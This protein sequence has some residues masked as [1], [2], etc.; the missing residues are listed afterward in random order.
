MGGAIG[1]ESEPGRG[2]TFSFTARFGRQPHPLEQAR[3]PAV[4][5]GPRG[6]RGS[7]CRGAAADPGGRG[8]RVQL[9]T[10]GAAAA[11]AGSRRAG[12]D[13]RP[14]GTGSGRRSRLRPLAPGR[15]HAGTRRLPGRAGDPGAGAGRR[16]APAGHRLDGARPEGR[17]R[18]LP[19]GRHGRLPREAGPGRGTVRGDRAGDIARGAPPAG[20]AGWRGP[21]GPARSG[22]AA[23]VL[24]RRR[25]GPARDVPGSAGLCPGPDRRGL[26][27]PPGRGCAAAARGRAQ[28][29]RAA[30]GILHGGR[31][32][33]VGPRGA[34]GA[35]PSSTRRGRW[36]NGSSRW[37]KSWFTRSRACRSRACA[38]G[39]RRPGPEAMGRASASV[40]VPHPARWATGQD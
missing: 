29:L 26:R 15:P 39:R 33:G 23:R 30:L 8:Q 36:S 27:R 25:R 16:G 5:L 19:R 3:R 6:G 13:R 7:P 14:G 31:R 21:L 24:R 38:A 9:A 20:T 11:V 32:R 17:P 10:P 18:A 4:G 1:V 12:G 2:S 22:R 37:P 35:R 28:A 34:C 40:R